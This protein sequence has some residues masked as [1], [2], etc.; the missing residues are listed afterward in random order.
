M[1][2]KINNL[3]SGGIITNYYCSS[4]CRH[5]LYAC[6]PS[7]P[8]DYLS[9]EK[10]LEVIRKIKSLNCT[11]AHIGGGEPFLNRDGLLSVL[12]I[13]KQEDFFI[14]YVETN[15]SWHKN[16]KD[17]T[18]FLLQLKEEGL[19]TLLISISPFHNEFIP[20]KKVK[21]VMNACQETGMNIFPWS[22]N[23]YSDIDSFNESD[24]ISLEMYNKKFGGDYVRNI[25]MRYW[26][27]YG[28]RALQIFKDMHPLYSVKEIISC[29]TSCSELND[30]SHFHIDLYGNYIPALC[31]GLSIDYRGL[32]REMDYNDYPLL[33]IL[34]G[35]GISGLYNYALEKYS[36]KI[37]GRFLSKCHLCLNIRQKLAAINPLNKELQPNH[38]YLE[39]NLNREENY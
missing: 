1:Q 24:K 29:N 37:E 36:I 4:K 25:P 26:I 35:E 33:S 8:K 14:E 7:W 23:F 38:F 2:L 18:E 27:H 31:S 3:Q 5:C 9:P 16:H 30:T 39:T 13:A 28:G 6:S 22:D 15:S 17:A 32:G 34:Y 11:S 12:R 10:A 19:N 21:G 20:F